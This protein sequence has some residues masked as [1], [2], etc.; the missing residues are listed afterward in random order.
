MCIS[1]LTSVSVL[2]AETSPPAACT[3]TGPF[4]NPEVNSINRCTGKVEQTAFN[5]NVTEWTCILFVVLFGAS[6]ALH[7]IQAIRSRR[8]YL[9]G[10]IFICAITETL[11]WA[12]RLWA[13]ISTEWY[14]TNGG[15]WAT[16]ETA[17]LMQISTLM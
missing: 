4:Y 1:C 11:G 17:F 9:L 7:L 13:A 5:Y 3:S 14:P 12:G 6:S 8:W 2:T 15:H 10:T 16:N